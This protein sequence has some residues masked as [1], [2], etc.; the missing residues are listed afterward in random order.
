[1]D[2]MVR[3]DYL[4]DKLL[5]ITNGN[6]KMAPTRFS[7]VKAN[8]IRSIGFLMDLL[9]RNDHTISRLLNTLNTNMPIRTIPTILSLKH[10]TMGS[11]VSYS[12]TDD[13]DI[14]LAANEI[15]KIYINL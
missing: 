14:L 2:D 13:D 3:F 8:T 4:H 7:M 1:M 12:N 5:I 9:I 10:A 15:L 6:S 11:F